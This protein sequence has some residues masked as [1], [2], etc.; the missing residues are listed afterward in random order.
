[1]KRNKKYMPN[2]LLFL[3]IIPGDRIQASHPLPGSFHDL[4]GLGALHR[5][6][7]DDLGQ[8]HDPVVDLVSAAALHCGSKWKTK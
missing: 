1:M 5:A 3:E 2:T 8:L 4:A 7:W 6:V